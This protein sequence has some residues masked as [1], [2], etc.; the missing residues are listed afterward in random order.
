M[1]SRRS[2]RTASVSLAG[3]PVAAG[4]RP[5]LDH[6]QLERR[7]PGD[8]DAADRAGL[9]VEHRQGVFARRQ[10]G[11]DH[12]FALAGRGGDVAVDELA[13]LGEVGGAG[14]GVAEDAR[15]G[16]E[17]RLDPALEVG[18]ADAAA[19]RLD[20]QAD[21]VRQAVGIAA[22]LRRGAAHRDPA[23]GRVG[24]DRVIPVDC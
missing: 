3:E 1:P 7:L 15:H 17:L 4:P 23:I 12:A 20:Q 5:G 22:E 10:A 2:R 16:R 24:R 13:Q 14:R 6:A 19:A 9:R 18:A 21:R 8:G 11:L